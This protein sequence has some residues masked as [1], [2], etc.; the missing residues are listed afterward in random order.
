MK[1]NRVEEDVW[2]ENSKT[3]MS[4]PEPLM[5]SSSKSGPDSTPTGCNINSSLFSVVMAFCHIY[6]C[7]CEDR[8]N[9][10]ISGTC[11]R[12]KFKGPR[13]ERDRD[14]HWYRSLQHLIYILTSALGM[15]RRRSTRPHSIWEISPFSFFFFGW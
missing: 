9:A 2:K 15:K 14:R 3:T 6:Y 4:V 1:R 8:H 11:C 10:N 7:L 12:V 13:R 5:T